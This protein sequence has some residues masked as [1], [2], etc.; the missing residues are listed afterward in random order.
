MTN[1]Y[2]ITAIIDSLI[3]HTV[4]NLQ[5][6][7]IKVKLNKLTNCMLKQIK[8][9]ARNNFNIK[10]EDFQKFLLLENIGT[11]ATPFRKISGQYK[12]KT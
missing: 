2:A 3:T 7:T 9:K 5:K 8:S 4:T 6:K 11:S 10:K 12:S 1:C